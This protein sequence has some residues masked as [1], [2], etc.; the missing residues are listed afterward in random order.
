MPC[1]RPMNATGRRV[2]LFTKD[3][4]EECDPNELAEM[5]KP[6]KPMMLRVAANS[7]GWDPA[8]AMASA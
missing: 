1:A 7:H 6:G 8:P 2:F 5:G 4:I 3:P